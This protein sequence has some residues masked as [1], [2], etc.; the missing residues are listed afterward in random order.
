[1]DSR[2]QVLKEEESGK[3]PN[4]YE[5][6]MGFALWASGRASCRKVRAGS[7]CANEEHRSLSTGYNGAASGV[8]NCLGPNGCY[9]EFMTKKN[10]E[11]TMNSGMCIG[12]HAEENASA[13]I[14]R[15]LI[16]SLTIFTTIFPCHTCAKNL[17]RYP[18]S[19][20]IFKTSYDEREMLSTLDL[21][22]K[23]KVEI[24]QL[25][26]SPERYFDIMFNQPEVKFDAWSPEERKRMQLLLRK[27]KS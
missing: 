22:Q 4:W 14:D 18:L 25:D 23:R 6:G 20:I 9:K 17:L 21:L 3:R 5:Y 11:D 24:Y 7:Y 19:K 10:Y 12:V 2:I 16:R 8:E 27:K 1:M 15:S 13:Y 26:L